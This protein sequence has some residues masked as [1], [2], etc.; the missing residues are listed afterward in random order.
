LK[1]EGKLKKDRR[2]YLDWEVGDGWG[3]LCEFLGEEKPEGEFPWGNRG[4]EEFK[5][6]A[7]QALEKM[8][9]RALLRLGVVVAVVAVAIAFAVR[10]S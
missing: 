1:I 2:Q 4:G 8:I 9:K 6:N 10:L 7:D 3:P 5:K